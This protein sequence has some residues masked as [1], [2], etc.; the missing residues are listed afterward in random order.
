MSNMGLSEWIGIGVSAIS[1]IIAIVALWQTHRQI[2]ISNKQQLF[3]RRLN[4]Y[5]E[6]NTLLRLLKDN[7][8]YLT[9]DSSFYHKNDL[10]F[11]WLTNCSELEGMWD[12]VAD[13]L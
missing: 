5:I 7:I 11:A 6:V 12:A 1:V 9:D 13:P 8:P 4:L 2:A 3:D 10:I